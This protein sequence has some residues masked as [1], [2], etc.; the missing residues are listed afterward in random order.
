MAVH[1]DHTKS[2]TTAVFPSKITLN[3][4]IPQM[5]DIAFDCFQDTVM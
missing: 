4:L 2:L 3:A 5:T 1:P